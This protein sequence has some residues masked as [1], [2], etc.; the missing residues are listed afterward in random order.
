MGPTCKR[1]SFKYFFLTKPK[2]Y[3]LIFRVFFYVYRS[4]WNRKNATCDD[5]SEPNRD[6]RTPHF[7]TVFNATAYRP[8]PT[9]DVIKQAQAKGNRALSLSFGLFRLVRVHGD[10]T[11]ISIS[12]VMLH[13]RKTVN[14]NVLVGSQFSLFDEII[15]DMIYVE[16]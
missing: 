4:I 13:K 14:R 7:R 5:K 12:F 6:N 3:P 1:R 11:H 15:K 9:K 10:S 2:I 16:I 8:D